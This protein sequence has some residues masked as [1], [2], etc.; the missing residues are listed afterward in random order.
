[1]KFRGKIAFVGK[2]NVKNIQQNLLMFLGGNLK[3][4]GGLKKEKTLELATTMVSLSFRLSSYHVQ[5][6]QTCAEYNPYVTCCN[7][8]KLCK[9]GGALGGDQMLS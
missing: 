2:E 4:R 3:I 5:H 1:M 9:G 6:T 8:Q 7:R